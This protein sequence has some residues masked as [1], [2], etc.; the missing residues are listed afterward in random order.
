MNMDPS[1][2]PRSAGISGGGDEF[3]FRCA[4]CDLLVENTNGNAYLATG[5]TDTKLRVPTDPRE[6][7]MGFTF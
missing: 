5:N 1:A 6:A 2:E 3:V 4:K 7:D